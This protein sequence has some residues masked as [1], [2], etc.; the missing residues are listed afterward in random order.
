MI[1]LLIDEMDLHQILY[2]QSESI[3]NIAYIDSFNLSDL[4]YKVNN[5]DLFQEVK[6]SDKT[7]HILIVDDIASNI[8]LLK[9]YLS[10]GQNYEL[11][12]AKT[13]LECIE[14]IASIEFDLLILDIQ[15]PDIDGYA[16]AKFLKQ[17][18][19]YK[20]IPIIF[21]TAFNKNASHV[22]KAIEDMGAVDYLYK[23]VDKAI[24]QAKVEGY[25]SIS[26]YRSTLEKN[27]N[28]LL[29]QKK[30]ID[31][32]NKAMVDNI[33]YAKRIQ[34][35]MLPQKH[36]L[37]KKFKDY[38]LSY[39]PKNILSGDFYYLYELDDIL[40]WAVG[41]CTG[42]GVSG[43]LLSMTVSTLLHK[44]IIE[45]SAKG[46][47]QVLKSLHLDLIQ[48]FEQSGNETQ[49]GAELGLV[50]YHKSN[51]SIEFSGANI[52]LWITG[53]LKDFEIGVSVSA[54]VK[55][56]SANKI[57]LGQSIYNHN[58]LISQRFKMPKGV[59]LMLQTDGLVDQ[60]GGPKPERFKRARL[61]ESFN[62]NMD[63]QKLGA[64]IEDSL[65]KWQ[66]VESQT[67]D[68]SFL[69]VSH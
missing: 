8:T 22:K 30:E 51:C 49:D 60:L 6:A 48:A 35:A 50:F 44:N 19:L 29:K 7:K 64:S 37:K 14:K 18:M 40:I 38:F 56:I 13:G 46:A 47:D 41:D 31:E 68:I 61:L 9:H 52:N 42:H 15:L 53:S 25:L 28:I 23:P 27:H 45:Q 17:S 66:G 57:V 59:I 12:S 21:L 63:C 58:N 32:T 69:L 39:K 54:N 33:N 2:L 16:I 34:A 10:S 43:A 26:S 36:S 62:P 24:I 5:I 65:N 3:V 4:S 1:I 20:S 55:K 11:H 67:D